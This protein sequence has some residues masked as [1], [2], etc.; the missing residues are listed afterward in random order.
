MLATFNK[1]KLIED[2]RLEQA[3]RLFDKDGSGTISVEEI[4]GI[5]GHSGP[6]SE[7]VWKEMVREVDSNEDGQVSI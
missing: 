7:K 3:F 6:V 4:K 5:F 1:V 2:N